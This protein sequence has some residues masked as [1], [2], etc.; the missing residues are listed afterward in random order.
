MNFYGNHNAC[1]STFE[2]KYY[3]KPKWNIQ[4]NFKRT[5]DIET[6]S[7]NPFNFEKVT[8][9]PSTFNKR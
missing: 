5:Q 4:N 3:M 9:K 1:F 2:K 7:L 8:P 6:L